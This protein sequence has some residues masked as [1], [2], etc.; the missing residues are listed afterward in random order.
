MKI[1][2]PFLSDT[3]IKYSPVLILFAVW[4]FLSVTQIIPELFLPSFSSVAGSWYRLLISGEIPLH[5][6]ASLWREAVGF[7]LSV[8]VGTALGIGMARSRFM[9]DFFDPL[10]NLIYPIP[11][12][13]LIPILIVW[14]GIG[15]LSKIA[16]IFLG[17]ILPVV[18]SSF[19]G[20]KGV[21]RFIIWSALNMGTGRRRIL[22]RV[23]IPAALPDILS[24]A[25][26]ALAISFVLLVSSEMLAS[27]LGL[28]F[29]IFFLGE[30]GDYAGM[31]AAIMTVT[32]LGFFAD[33]VYLYFMNRILKW[34]EEQVT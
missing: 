4:E 22:W 7:A 30:G 1:S 18:V 6:A 26:T 16:V 9:E 27:N 14:L 34:R 33:R 28:G 13:A 31:F 12:S 8:L 17:C 19:N 20:A 2:K 21:D 10:I 29:L 23:I 5:T 24:G 15:H 11:K 32:L 25:R 3:F